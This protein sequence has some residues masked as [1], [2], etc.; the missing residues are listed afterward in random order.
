MYIIKC[1]ERLATS[2][3][4][5]VSGERDLT[6]EE[7]FPRA[8]ERERERERRERDG[9]LLYL[10]TPTIPIKSLSES[11]TSLYLLPPRPEPPKSE[12][13]AET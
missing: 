7:D 11:T 9:K 5:L 2:R 12:P 13:Q 6:S 1:K 3:L 4:D 8:S 10:L